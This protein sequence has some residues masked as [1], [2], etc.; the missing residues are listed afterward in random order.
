MSNGKD[1]SS[2]GGHLL[3]QG[4]TSAV[5]KHTSL[6]TN[7]EVFAGSQNLS[8]EGPLHV[9]PESQHG[10][11]HIPEKERGDEESVRSTD[12]T[13]GVNLS[14]VKKHTPWRH[15]VAFWE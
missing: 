14:L 7:R 6:E 8:E 11:F 1:K 15:A 2:G 3:G 5:N 12:Q 4:R 9:N 13:N 10:R